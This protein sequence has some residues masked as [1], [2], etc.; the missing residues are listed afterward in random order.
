[1]NYLCY[2]PSTC[3]LPVFTD[4]TIA[5]TCPPCIQLVCLKCLANDRS[6]C[7]KCAT[8]STLSG[9]RCVCS[10]NY[11]EFYTNIST[12]S[13]GLWAGTTQSLSSC[14]LNCTL[15][16]SHCLNFDCTN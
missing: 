5:N 14:R 4:W 2:T 1:M 3:P 13:L 16:I 7:S 9:T 8:G 10:T 15:V 6:S 11:V 12:S